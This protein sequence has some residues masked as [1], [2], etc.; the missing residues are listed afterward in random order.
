MRRY[1]FVLFVR[2]SIRTNDKNEIQMQ[3]ILDGIH[4]LTRYIAVCCCVSV[5]SFLS[6]RNDDANGKETK[7][8]TSNERTEGKLKINEQ[9]HM[10]MFPAIF[11][12]VLH[13]LYIYVY[14]C[15]SVSDFVCFLIM[16]ALHQYR[17]FFFPSMS[18][19]T[20]VVS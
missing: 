6:K 11:I 17:F 1:I 20:D 13:V 19:D 9:M 18:L 15:V 12:G 7:A 4:V 16:Q 14:I 3:C 10:H 8:T 2:P 5:C